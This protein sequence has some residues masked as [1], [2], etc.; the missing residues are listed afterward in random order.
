M[1]HVCRGESSRTAPV[2]LSHQELR[3]ECCGHVRKGRKSKVTVSIK[4]RDSYLRHFILTFSQN[5]EAH[6]QVDED[7]GE[8]QELHK[9]VHEQVPF[10]QACKSWKAKQPVSYSIQ[11]QREALEPQHLL[12]PGWFQAPP[13]TPGPCL[14]SLGSVSH[15]EDNTEHC[16]PMCMFANLLS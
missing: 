6:R 7:P 1:E 14:P 8:A 5:K 12:S 16:L 10:L 13:Q 15:K 4:G 2:S 9:V 11:P 3:N